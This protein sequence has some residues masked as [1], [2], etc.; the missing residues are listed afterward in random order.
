MSAALILG[1]LTIGTLTGCGDATSSTSSSKSGTT[2]GASTTGAGTD[3]T[4]SSE[5]SSDTDGAVIDGI[6]VWLGGETQ[7]VSGVSTF[8]HPVVGVGD[9]KTGSY[10][11]AVNTR[12]DDPYNSLDVMDSNGK[13]LTEASTFFGVD[14]VA[15]VPT[16]LV[17][18]WDEQATSSFE[19]GTSQS[20]LRLVPLD[21]SKMTDLEVFGWESGPVSVSAQGDRFLSAT[22]VE[23]SSLVE[24]LGP[25]GQ[26]VS[27]LPVRGQVTDP[28][29]YGPVA[30]IPQ[31]DTALVN[32]VGESKTTIDVIS[33]PDGSATSIDLPE[34]V[35][36]RDLRTDGTTALVLV[37][38]KVIVIDLATK[39]ITTTVDVPDDIVSIDYRT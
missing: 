34:G 4:T 1:L 10:I 28:E 32:H 25:D 8:D 9:D 20:R 18:W 26:P 29:A 33:V 38:G 36:V 22:A 39:K 11:V 15:G 2:I 21:G 37:V 6:K 19:A 14:D 17:S 35:E 3:S 13:V 5:K 23:G 31:Q 12:P 27:D 7:G 16:V 30:L 24:L